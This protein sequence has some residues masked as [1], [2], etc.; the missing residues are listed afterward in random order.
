MVFLKTVR[1]PQMARPKP[2]EEMTNVSIRA[3]LSLVEELRGKGTQL[4]E[5]TV[6]YWRSLSSTPIDPRFASIQSK[7]FEYI[8]EDPA[9]P[10][11]YSRDEEV[12]ERIVM[13]R[14]LID[15]LEA[16]ASDISAAMVAAEKV[17]A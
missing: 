7:I 9:L 4:S 15:K 13:A 12:V 5:I 11:K 14:L 3:P 1:Y 6:S 2:A 10:Q 17:R 8:Q 16:T